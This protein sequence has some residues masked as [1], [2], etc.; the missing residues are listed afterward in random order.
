[1]GGDLFDK[2]KRAFNDLAHGYKIRICNQN[3]L[4]VYAVRDGDKMIIYPTSIKVGDVVVDER[5]N[6]FFVSKTIDNNNFKIHV[7][8]KEVLI[9]VVILEFNQNALDNLT[10]SGYLNL[11]NSISNSLVNS[12]NVEQIIIQANDNTL[13]NIANLSIEDYWKKLRCELKYTYDNQSYS[14]YIDEVEKSFKEKRPI[15]EHIQSNVLKKVSEGIR[16]FIIDFGAKFFAELVNRN[17]K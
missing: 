10:L 11:S 4:S 14:A 16:G 8:E 5:N 13:S 15:N 17:I 6:R 1:M 2:K 7:D 3:N 12:G 9:S